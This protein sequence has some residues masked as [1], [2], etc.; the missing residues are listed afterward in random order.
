[1]TAFYEKDQIPLHIR[2]IESYEIEATSGRPAWPLVDQEL[3]HIMVKRE[4]RVEEER[5]TQT[6]TQVSGYASEKYLLSMIET[7]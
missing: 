5:I 3:S 1:M 2:D 7:P 6:P 4:I